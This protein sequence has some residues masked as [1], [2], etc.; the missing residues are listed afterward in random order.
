MAAVKDNS[1]VFAMK[2]ASAA[3]T[4]DQPM[5]NKRAREGAGEALGDLLVTETMKQASSMKQFVV[6]LTNLDADGRVGFLRYLG[7]IMKERR[8]LVKENGTSLYKGISASAGV[9]LSEFTTLAKALDKSFVPDMEQGYHVIVVAAREWLRALG[10]GDKRGRKATHGLV[11]AMKY[12][13][14][15]DAIDDN[16]KAA[17]VALM[18]AAQELA[19]SMG[20][21]ADKGED[22]P[23]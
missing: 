3:D 22:A 5:A 14:K 9:R 4:L 20:L 19:V 17:I 10:E 6:S 8:A 11:K 1:E 2:P 23:M 21:A 16:D 7:T 12:L 18:N 13:E 15:L